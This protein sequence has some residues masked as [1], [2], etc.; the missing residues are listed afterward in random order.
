MRESRRRFLRGAA[1]AAAAAALGLRRAGARSGDASGRRAF[2][3]VVVGAGVFGAWTAL[4]LARAGRRVALVDA[5]GP[6]NPRASSGGETRVI[7]MGYGADEW[8]T[9]WSRHSLDRWK[10]LAASSG[11][12]LFEPSGVLWMARAED[13]LTL[14]TLTTLA[15]V[16][17]RHERVDRKEL[18]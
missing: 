3:V 16:G 5:Y 13:P 12:T 2:D 9:L 10:E 4:A 7:R 18:D 1:G 17:V 15:R 6:G 14:S 8:Y 11:E